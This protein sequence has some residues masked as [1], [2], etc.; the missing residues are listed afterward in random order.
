MHLGLDSLCAPFLYLNFNDE[1]LA[2]ACL[3]AFIPKYLHGM[4][5]R[6]NA[7]VIQEYL[8]KF[9]HMQAFHDPELFNHLNEISF[10]PDLY[11]IPWILTMFA[12]VFPLHNI[13]HL[14]DQLLL[15]DS[16]FPLSIGL[17]VLYQ[18]RERLMQAE[19]ND[20]I[21]LFSDLPAIDIEKCVQD[22][23]RIFH[24][25]PKS[26]TWR[27]FGSGSQDTANKS[28]LQID[29]ITLQQQKLEKVPRI[30]GDDLLQLLGL[31]QH[32]L[33]NRKEEMN[34]SEAGALVLDIRSPQ[35]HQRGTLPG[36]ITLPKSAKA[37]LE[38]TISSD[39]IEELS[40]S[41]GKTICIAGTREQ[42]SETTEFANSLLRQNI[43]RIC[44]L[45]NGMD[46]FRFTPGV[47][48]VPNT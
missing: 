6:D 9:S 43:P 4:F 29:S 44:T 28:G 27:K 33:S 22:S 38:E 19:F 31:S 8:A 39:L 15:G 40:K 35:E 1:P 36:T 18:L 24:T 10:I 48:V 20:C 14:W 5:R 21:L 34:G 47:L 32:D 3:S 16:S 25:T 46:I 45:H 7:E 17:A 41:A 13:F 23:V 26:L 30:G 2:Y 37:P 42:E 12:H 11:A